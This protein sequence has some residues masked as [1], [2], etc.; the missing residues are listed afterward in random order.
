MSDILSPQSGGSLWRQGG[1]RS[2]ICRWRLRRPWGVAE[3][4]LRDAEAALSS[5]AHGKGHA[6][7][8][9][10]RGL[11]VPHKGG[12]LP[13]PVLLVVRVPQREVVVLP[14][15]VVG[16]EEL[17]PALGHPHQ[18][19]CGDGVQLL[20]NLQHQLWWQHICPDK[21][22]HFAEASLLFGLAPVKYPSKD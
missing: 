22:G 15:D 3:A 14:Q 5:V 12:A 8:K 20:E 17:A 2:C 18:P 21:V 1:L 9:A 7:G 6:P 10:Y 19:H 13:L 11:V 4:V 16:G